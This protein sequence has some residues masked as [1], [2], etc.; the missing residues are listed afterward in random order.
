MATMTQRETQPVDHANASGKTAVVFIH[1]LWLLP[2]SWDR[3][4]PDVG[5]RHLVFM[6]CGFG[7]P[8]WTQRSLRSGARP[9]RNRRTA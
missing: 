2:S 5:S 7:G 3:S 6:P 8:A 1:G 9:P 4:P